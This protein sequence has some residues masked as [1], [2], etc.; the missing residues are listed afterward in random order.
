[1]DRLLEATYGVEQR[2]FWWTGL[3]AFVGPLAAEA[4]RGLTAAQASI[5]SIPFA[6]ATFDLVTALDVLYSLSEAEE[7]AAL[8]EIT[9]SSSR[10]ARSSSMSRRFLSCAAIHSIFGAEVRRST[11]RQLP[12]TVF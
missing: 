12:S 1:M 10:A 5:T 3:R 8:A 9:A 6:A 7:A 2:R 11:R 4:T